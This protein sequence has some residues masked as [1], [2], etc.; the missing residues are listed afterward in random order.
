MR[1]KKTKL[2]TQGPMARNVVPDRTTHTRDHAY[3]DAVRERMGR[4]LAKQR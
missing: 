3:L 4:L 1:G 2:W